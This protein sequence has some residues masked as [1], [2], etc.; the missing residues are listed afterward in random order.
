MKKLTL[1]RET[2]VDIESHLQAEKQRIGA[3]IKDLSALDPFRDTERLT[4]N[5][6]SDTEASEETNH[7]RYQAMVDELKSK[8]M[9]IE[10]ALVRIQKGSYGLCLS[11]HNLIDTDRLA[12]M[13]TATLCMD[14][15]K[16]RSG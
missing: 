7:E 16:K 14:C 10:S 6:A 2:L 15:Q 11:C 12:A 4:D 13:P 9:E 5:A 8:L 3:Q 1:P